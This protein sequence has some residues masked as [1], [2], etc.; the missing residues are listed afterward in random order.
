M[1]DRPE[2]GL[3]FQDRDRGWTG[4]AVAAQHRV[5]GFPNCF[6]NREFTR[7]AP[8]L[9]LHGQGR[10]ELAQSWMDRAPD[11]EQWGPLAAARSSRL[12]DTGDPVYLT[13]KA[14]T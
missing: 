9:G 6:R 11:A 1:L 2:Q 4:P 7:V 8:D 13:G 3:G 10:V 5:L 12:P 14:F